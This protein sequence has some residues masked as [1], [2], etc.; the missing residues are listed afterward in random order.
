MIVQELLPIC[1]LSSL[2][3]VEG[4]WN[5]LKRIFVLQLVEPL[6]VIKQGLLVTNVIVELQMV[7]DSK[8]V[9]VFYSGDRFLLV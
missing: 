4:M 7:V 5:D 2:L 9:G 3:D 8:V 1:V 6:D